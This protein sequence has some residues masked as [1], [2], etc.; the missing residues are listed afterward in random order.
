MHGLNHITAN[1]RLV[2][3]AW[4][5]IVLSGFCISGVFIWNSVDNWHKNPVATTIS[6]HPIDQVTL[7]TIYV[8]PPKNTYTNL[9]HDLVNIFNTT[10]TNDQEASLIY[11]IDEL[12]YQEEQGNAMREIDSLVEEHKFSNWYKGLSK[13]SKPYIG[14]RFGYPKKLIEF[15]TFSTHGFIQSP[16]FGETYQRDKFYE[17]FDVH[18]TLKNILNKVS[19][20]QKLVLQIEMDLK[21]TV[22]GEETIQIFNYNGWNKYYVGT[23]SQTGPLNKTF[24]FSVPKKDLEIYFSRDLQP[25]SKVRC[26]KKLFTGN[27]V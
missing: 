19:L 14:Q 22:G 12:V 6:T 17:I 8:C 27:L 10:L 11:F 9:N 16:Y 2:K 13:I 21:E 4:I 24:L 25:D 20:E 3:V 23:F 26:N 1:N 15:S 7:P 18:I 5:G